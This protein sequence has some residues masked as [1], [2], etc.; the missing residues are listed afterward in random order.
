ML[1]PTGENN[2]G[3]DLVCMEEL[4][5][6]INETLCECNE[7]CVLECFTNWLNENS[8]CV[9]CNQLN[10]YLKENGYKSRINE[11]DM[12]GGGSFNTPGSVNGMGNPATPTNGGTNAG[13]YDL[14]K[15]GSGDKFGS[16]ASRKKGKNKL[17]KK[18]QDFMK[19]RKKV[20]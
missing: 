4:A 3:R 16:I 10:S 1:Y 13:F 11:D 9:E 8:Y 5:N 7:S 15:V 6:E 14:S 20:K 19:V 18:F 17:I 2:E 12:G